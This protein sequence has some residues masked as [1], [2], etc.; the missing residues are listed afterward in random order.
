M[1][2]KKKAI[3]LGGTTAHIA[4]I[5]NLHNRGYYVI[6]VDFLENPPA[7]KAADLHIKESTLDENKVLKIARENHVEL[8][9]SAC[10]DQANITACYVMEKLGKTPPYPYSTA[11]RI[12][13]KGYMKKKMEENA[14]PTSKYIY[15]NNEENIDV[16]SLSYPLMVKPADCNSASGVKKAKN[17]IELS[18]FL[19][20]AIEYS[21]SNKAVIEEVVKGKEVSIYSFV[22]NNKARIIMISERFSVIE[23]DQQV[24][25][26]YATLAPARISNEIYMRLEKICTQ[27]ANSFNLNN[28][29]LHVQAFIN[30]NDI[31]IIEFAPRVG[32]GFSYKTILD[33]TGFD[34][35]DATVDSFL[36]KKVIINNVHN[37]LMYYSINLIYGRSAVFNRISGGEELIKDQIIEDLFYHKSP[38]AKISNEKAAAARVGAYIIKARDINELKEKTLK[39]QNKLEVYSTND[40]KIMRKELSILRDI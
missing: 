39:A 23:G 13:N 24:L 31:N 12:T 8:V 2:D 30:D 9:I 34:I 22:E 7:K 29:P 27:I 10:V 40:E 28:T 38:G 21:R 16:S 11:I 17:S 4:L 26:C 14:I 18:I 35:I 20:E 3:V 19:K 33:N 5:N 15:V 25:K 32:G 36:G 6:L 1:N 37:P